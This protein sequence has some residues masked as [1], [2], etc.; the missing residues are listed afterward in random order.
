MPPETRLGVDAGANRWDAS[1]TSSLNELFRVFSDRI[2]RETL[3]VLR[4]KDG[5]ISLNE[6]ADVLSDDANQVRLS[7]VHIHLPMLDAVGLIRW[8]RTRESI[9]LA[10]IPYQY[11]RL[12]EIIEQDVQ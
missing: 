12:F 9:E 2:R 4:T 3:T 7:L 1:T 10:T 6:L 8:N 11:R 5:P